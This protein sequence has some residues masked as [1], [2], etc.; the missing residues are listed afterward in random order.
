MRLPTGVRACRQASAPADTT[1]NSDWLRCWPQH[2]MQGEHLE[3]EDVAYFHALI[4]GL[5][6]MIR[7]SQASGQLI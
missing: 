2:F 7:D 5:V 1:T 3:G 6:I 4:M